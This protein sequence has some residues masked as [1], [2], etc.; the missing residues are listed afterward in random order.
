[1]D[2]QRHFRP[3]D[4]LDGAVAVELFP[5]VDAGVGGVVV[6]QVELATAGRGSTVAVNQAESPPSVLTR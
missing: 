4:G 2:G 6:T 5:F 3:L 1:M